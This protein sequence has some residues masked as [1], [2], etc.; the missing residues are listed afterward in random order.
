MSPPNGFDGSRWFSDLSRIGA[1]F[2]NIMPEYTFD[3]PPGILTNPPWRT[4]K[5]DWA[6]T[7]TS[8]SIAQDLIRNVTTTFSS[9]IVPGL[10]SSTLGSIL[11]NLPSW[12]DMARGI[13]PVNILDAEAELTIAEMKSW[14]LEEGLPIAWVPRATTIDALHA[15]GSASA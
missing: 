9:L 1:R 15:A 4:P 10:T 13:H 12:E 7:I 8:S 5:T 11:A 6:T 14:M 3:L 2:G